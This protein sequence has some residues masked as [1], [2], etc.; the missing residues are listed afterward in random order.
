MTEA[1]DLL[2]ALGTWSASALWLPLL[3]WT[4]LT[5][6]VYVIVQRARGWHPLTRYRLL[7]ALLFTLP[8]GLVAATWIDASSVLAGWL[9]LSSTASGGT[10]WVLPP[11]E[12]SPTTAPSD[13]LA[14]DGFHALGLLTVIAIALGVGRLLRLLRS[15]RAMDSLRTSVSKE[16]SGRVRQVAERI[17]QDVGVNRSV[18]V[19]L[20][21]DAVVPLTYGT[22]RPVILLPCSLTDEPEA[23][24]MTLIHELI[25]IRRRDVLA[26]WAEQLVAAVFAVHPGL[27]RL[28][29]AIETAREMACDAEALRHLR[30]SR[31]GYA[32]LLFRFSTRAAP[33]PAYAVSI[34]ET[35]SSLKE[36]IHAMTRLNLSD[37][38][39]PRYAL[40][41]ATV[42]LVTLGLG[43]V[44][45]S[46][47]VT[48][49]GTDDPEEAATTQSGPAD[50]EEIFVVVEDRPEL[51]G[52]MQA[53]HEVIQYPEEAK[54]AGIEGRVFVQF[55]VDENGA[56]QDLQVTRSAHELLDRAALD[57]VEQLEFEP[58]KQ[59][60]KAVKVQMS[61]PVTFKL[62]GEESRTTS[63]ANQHPS[64]AEVGP[65]QAENR[66]MSFQQLR[67]D[68]DVVTG[69]IVDAAT[70]QPLA[71]TNIVVPNTN[72]GSATKSDGSFT[73]RADASS[74]VASFVGY[75]SIEA[76]DK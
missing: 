49:P 66:E 45:C 8:A 29:R 3:A 69:R 2:H 46:D 1:L 15:R 33:H 31:K 6:P 53:L 59:R 22:H 39:H 50:G 47:A 70:G 34:T 61:L 35:A 42:L 21:D 23:L 20:T 62:P 9:A 16:D 56:P 7:Q 18:H 58:G 13:A 28:L 57:A 64:Q 73:L 27:P 52:G 19:T 63:S 24:R 40:L 71:G 30:C 74:I 38:K 37:L 55:V 11:A 14:L 25:H 43:V 12:V 5:L 51:K 10:M 41:A 60:G 65:L 4:L 54:E 75:E 68:D 32:D 76:V 72:K 44:A 48:P 67:F 26:R 36:R 17:A